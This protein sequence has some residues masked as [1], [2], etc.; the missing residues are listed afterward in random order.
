MGMRLSEVYTLTVEELLT[1]YEAWAEREEMARRTTWEQTRFLAH[2]VLM[3][4][5]KKRLRLE[6][7]A[8]FPWEIKEEESLKRR[9]TEDE[10]VRM[11]RRFGDE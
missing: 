1:L 5:S 6:D 11:R 8:R 3:P 7:V 10:I 9:A 4:Y 2:C